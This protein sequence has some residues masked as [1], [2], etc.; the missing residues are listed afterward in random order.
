[1]AVYLGQFDYVI[2]HLEGT[3]N[4][5]ADLL[6]R[7]RQCTQASVVRQRLATFGPYS[8]WHCNLEAMPS[9]QDIRVLQQQ[10]IT[11]SDFE[12]EGKLQS[13]EHFSADDLQS[14]ATG[15]QKLDGKVWIP[16]NA[17][18]MHM[19]LMVVAHT[20]ASGHR[21]IAATLL[22]LKDYYW[23]SMQADVK[24][25]IQACLSCKDTGRGDKIPRPFG[26][27]L[28]GQK[29]N[30]VVHMDYLYI[31]EAGSSSLDGLDIGDSKYLLVLMDDY[32]QIVMLLPT[33][34]C[35]AELAAHG[36]MQ[37]MATYGDG[38]EVL[39]S[40]G[41]T[42]FKNQLIYH[43]GQLMGWQHHFS[44]ANMSH[45]HGTCERVMRE[46]LRTFKAILNQ[47]GMRPDQWRDVV[48]V[49]QYALNTAPRTR[50]MG[51]T[52]FHMGIGNQAEPLTMVIQSQE[53]AG[54]TNIPLTPEQVQ[55]H[56]K[57]LQDALAALHKPVSEAAE[58]SRMR[59]RV[60]QSQGKRAGFEIGDFVMVARVKR[61]GRQHKLVA[62]WMGPY[63]VTGTKSEH[64]FVVQHLLTGAISEHH[65]GRLS[66]YADASLNVS[67]EIKDS[68]V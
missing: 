35:N 11:A 64:V 18:E 26:T 47:A 33:A 65:S 68:I 46:I 42:H 36:L 25:F 31:G 22:K 43:L 6:S 15:L 27:T 48:N 50:K 1:W 10:A 9:F 21:G 53:E 41:P 20:G 57:D 45:T 52:P 56:T 37:W 8:T 2:E 34:T 38:V 5:W 7:W 30:A 44:M 12:T 23:A 32:S 49:V 28:H 16:A 4:T 59:G 55:A 17:R 13:G 51:L 62:T 14:D 29:F 39:V 58:A 67:Q 3:R 63:R 61:R 40:D 66:W 54:W 24:Q 60:T 19:R